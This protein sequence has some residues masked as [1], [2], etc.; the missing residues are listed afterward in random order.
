M[1]IQ[2]DISGTVP[3]PP[4]KGPASPTALACWAVVVILAQALL[5][6]I[7]VAVVLAA[8]KLRHNHPALRLGIVVLGVTVTV[9]FLLAAHTE[10]TSGSR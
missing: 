10:G 1:S 2:A 5:A 3:H 8:T 9:L 7:P 4:R 6:A